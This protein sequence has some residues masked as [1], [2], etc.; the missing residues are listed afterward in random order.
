MRVTV[1]VTGGVTVGVRAR[2]NPNPSPNPNPKTDPRG[3]VAW[4]ERESLPV[5]GGGLEVPRLAG[6]RKAQ[7]GVRRLV[8]AIELHRQPEARLGWKR[9]Q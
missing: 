1:R 2:A 8:G 4:L 5:R 3:G 9:G 6:E 7:V